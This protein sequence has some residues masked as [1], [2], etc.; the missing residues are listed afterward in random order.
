MRATMPGGE[1]ELIVANRIWLRLIGLMRLGPA[2]LKPI[3]FPRCGS[4][5]TFWMRTPIDIVWLEMTEDGATVRAVREALPPRRTARGGRGVSALELAP[6]AA[7]A[8][9]L[10]PGIALSLASIAP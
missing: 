7:G 8:L 2:D 10:V 9:G 3:L 4:L 5:H 6:G 1:I